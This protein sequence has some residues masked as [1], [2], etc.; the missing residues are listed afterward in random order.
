M[1]DMVWIITLGFLIV[2]ALIM[3]FRGC[4]QVDVAIEINTF[5]SP[6]Y[7]V[8]IFSDRHSLEDGSVEDEVVIGLLFVN[9]V[10]VF[11]KPID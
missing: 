6:F 5:Q 10:V 1:N 9:I 11:W 8:G 2:L 4:H 7:K 3:G